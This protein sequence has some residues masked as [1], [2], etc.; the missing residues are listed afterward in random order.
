MNTSPLDVTTLYDDR[1]V[2]GHVCAKLKKGDIRIGLG[3]VDRYRERIDEA[4]VLYGEPAENPAYLAG[5][6]VDDFRSDA[7]HQFGNIPLIPTVPPGFSEVAEPE[8]MAMAPHRLAQLIED[9]RKGPWGN[10]VDDDG[11][12][13]ENAA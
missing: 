4:L 7:A 1:A 13:I 3:L 5:I 2:A 11:D 8:V 6:V 12:W 10:H 9:S